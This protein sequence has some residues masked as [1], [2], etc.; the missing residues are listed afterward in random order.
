MY[1]L[2]YLWDDNGLERFGTESE[3]DH[4]DGCLELPS[5][6]VFFVCGEVSFPSL[7]PRPGW[8]TRTQAL[9]NLPFV[10]PTYI[11]EPY[12]SSSSQSHSSS[13]SSSSLSSVS[14]SQLEG[15]LAPIRAFEASPEH[16][17][18]LELLQSLNEEEVEAA[19]TVAATPT[20][21]ASLLEQYQTLKRQYIASKAQ[22]ALLDHL[23][24]H[25]IHND[26]DGRDGKVHMPPMPTEPE[27]NALQQHHEEL[28]RDVQDALQRLNV[29]AQQ[30]RLQYMAWQSRKDELEQR[31]REF[32]QAHTN[33]NGTMVGHE[34]DGD[35]D[36]NEFDNDNDNDNDDVTEDMLTAQANKLASLQLR[37]AELLRQIQLAK[38]EHLQ[39]CQ[40]EQ[41]Q[42]ENLPTEL[43]S[44]A[45]H[46]TS[47]AASGSSHAAEAASTT[48]TT[49]LQQLREHN[50]K[51]QHKIDEYGEMTEFYQ[52]LRECLEELRGVKVV[53]VSYHNPNTQQNT[54]RNATSDAME[55]DHNNK[56][57]A[58]TVVVNDENRNQRRPD[59]NSN[60]MSVRSDPTSASN[61]GVPIKSPT[62]K[63]NNV[64][65]CEFLLLETYE[66]VLELDDHPAATSRIPVPEFPGAVLVDRSTQTSDGN[67]TTKVKNA[68][69]R[70]V[71]GV[72]DNGGGL[73]L[74][75]LVESV[76]S[77]HS[78]TFWPTTADAVRWILTE[79]LARLHIRHKRSEELLR[80]QQLPLP[81]GSN[82]PSSTANVRVALC[83]PP[84]ATND[85]PP[86][87]G[88]GPIT[89]VNGD[90]HVECRFPVR[91]RTV[92]AVL[93]LT[94]D[95]PWV[96]GSVYLDRLYWQAPENGSAS[97]ETM[98]PDEDMD[99]EDDAFLPT[100]QAKVNAQTLQFVSPVDLVQYL[101][102]E[103]A[104][105][106]P[107]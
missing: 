14:L 94:P 84:E 68:Y 46:R 81:C 16:N 42:L 104:T 62:V 56:G 39:L 41:H 101:A 13:S 100:L 98:A 33:V 51:L 97:D 105:A 76:T 10:P 63:S 40:Q 93:C 26:K 58:N 11:M 103:L 34:I 17:Q 28:Q 18:L 3:S 23:A 83:C 5:R 77:E 65:V 19:T 85:H 43:R 75:D 22:K 15:M 88:S 53:Q 90:Q 32:Q 4:H 35:N 20:S 95:C 107:F 60:N 86:P 50:A 37:K 2:R 67:S 70:N 74:H 78:R 52:G 38:Q 89:T 54:A 91:S 80:L 64:L 1:R 47:N 9:P 106:L 73:S 45:V 7:H 59:N 82:G 30:V 55:R 21:S 87:G 49:R 44:H 69:F 29:K 61:T 79:A 8:N 66:L 31:V 102:N 27:R 96:A 6:V 25:G 71:V 24:Q 72:N 99:D 36:N 92:V 48:T 57:R 12:S